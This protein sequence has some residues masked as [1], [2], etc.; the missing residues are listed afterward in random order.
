MAARSRSSGAGVASGSALLTSTCSTC[1]TSSD[2]EGQ[3]VHGLIRLQQSDFLERDEPAVGL[4]K[5]VL[6]ARGELAGF[7]QPHLTTGARPD[8]ADHLAAEHSRAAVGER[9]RLDLDVADD[10]DRARRRLLVQHRSVQGAPHALA[11]PRGVVVDD[12][13]VGAQ[14]VG[15]VP[16][17]ALCVVIAHWDPVQTIF[18]EEL[19]P[20]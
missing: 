17:A 2:Q 1:S 14:V 5:V 3:A 11:T 19:E 18:G 4:A 16:G 6:S 20:L 12:V 8:L 13:D 15:P 7:V 9:L 10:V